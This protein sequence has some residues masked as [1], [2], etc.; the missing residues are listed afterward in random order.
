MRGGV[1]HPCASVVPLLPHRLNVLINSL[2][3]A[4]AAGRSALVSRGWTVLLLALVLR[5]IVNRT[6]VVSEPSL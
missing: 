5:L 6:R 2:S 1:L 3:F 4:M